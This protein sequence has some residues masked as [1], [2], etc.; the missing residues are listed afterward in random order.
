M[1]IAPALM[2]E[3]QDAAMIP[4]A[5]AQVIAYAALENLTLKVGNP[6]LSAVYQ[7]KRD[8]M[9]RGMEQAYLKAVPRRLIKGTPTAG[10]RFLRNPFGPLRFS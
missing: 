3:D 5:Y 1:L 10:T 2:Q 4:A 6:A 9:A 8:I 7:R